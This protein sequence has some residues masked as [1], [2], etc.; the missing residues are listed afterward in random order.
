MTGPTRIMPRVTV[1]ALRHSARARSHG[2]TVALLAICAS[3]RYWL[4]RTPLEDSPSSRKRFALAAS[5]DRGNQGSAS[6]RA[7][8]PARLQEAQC[9][10]ESSCQSDICWRT[11]DQ[12]ALVIGFAY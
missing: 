4:L 10:W 5:W 9:L 12:G 8:A 1:E 7:V 11:D 3:R 6:V 2:R